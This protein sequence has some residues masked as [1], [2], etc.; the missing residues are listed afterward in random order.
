MK[1]AFICSP[2][3]PTCTP[4]IP[5]TVEWIAPAKALPDD[6][7][8]VLLVLNDD[9][10]WPG[11]RDGDIWRYI[12]AMPIITERVTHWMPLPAP[13]ATAGGLVNGVQQDGFSRA[14]G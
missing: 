2:L 1:E 12:D 10:V 6:D 11:Y 5:R 3:L 14:S 4:D 13:P 9:E 8:L 7:A